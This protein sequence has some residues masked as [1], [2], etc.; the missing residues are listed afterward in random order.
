MKVGDRIYIKYSWGDVQVDIIERISKKYI[1]ALSGELFDKETRLI[2]EPP[3]NG[4]NKFYLENEI[5]AQGI[6]KY[7]ELTKKKAK[8]LSLIMWRWLAKTGLDKEDFFVYNKN[9]KD[10]DLF[11]LF[12]DD[13]LFCPLCSIFDECNKDC[14]IYTCGYEDSIYR[15]WE[16]C[17]DREYR[18]MYAQQ[19]VE[20]I[21]AWKIEEDE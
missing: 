10:N 6:K 17:E 4:E 15:T 13:D 12:Y 14:P 2:V 3:Y 18:K 7:E 5:E 1:R 11:Y 20:K 16:K 19:I 21:D 9:N 8:E